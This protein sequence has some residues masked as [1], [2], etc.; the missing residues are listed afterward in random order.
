MSETDTTVNL[1]N[2]DPY[3]F[4]KYL[5][6][7]SPVFRD[8]DGPWQVARY[9]DVRR[10]L[11][12]H[13]VF[14]SNVTLRDPEENGTPTMLFSDPPVHGRLRK[15]VSRAFSP[16]NINSQRDMITTRCEELMLDMKERK[17]V[18]LNAALASP[19]PITVIA[20]MLGV[21]DGDMLAFKH[22]SVKVFS[23][24]GDILFAQPAADVVAA[25]DEM[26]A[27]FLNRIHDIRKH[28]E[29][30]L[31][32]KLISYETEEGMLDDEE[33]LSFCRLLLIA[34]NETTTG[35]IIGLVR[36]FHEMPEIF[37]QLKSN[38][39]LAPDIVEETL[40]FYSPFSATVRRASQDIELAGQ[41]IL[42]GDLLMPLIASANR[43]EAVFE[44][45]DQF[46][47]DRSPNP[48]LG[49]GS[50]IHNCLGAALARLE[51]EIALR[52]MAKHLKS[53]QLVDYDPAALS[54]FVKPEVIKIR[55]EPV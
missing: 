1:E 34:G 27:Y 29:D 30:T 22:W 35:L 42:K 4:Y 3:A 40:R 13:P 43:D 44:Q 46:I 32:G 41:H 21:E 10:V 33:I 18:D 38:P 19:L 48:H 17:E 55:V 47:A 54:E 51:G 28:P 11:R 45:A 8:K 6:E 9:D 25:A 26:N 16:G 50:G 53:I 36:V 24:I 14:S 37:A 52:S 15:L 20:Q 7:N 2:V 23:N 49:F 5:R 12:E 31:L 39:D